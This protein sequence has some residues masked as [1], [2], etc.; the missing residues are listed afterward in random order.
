[1]TGGSRD[2]CIVLCGAAGRADHVHD[3]GLGRVPGEF[4]RCG[5]RGEIQH[6]IGLRENRERVVRECYVERADAGEFTCILAEMGRARP[7]DCTD[8]AR[9]LCRM[10]RPD[11]RLPHAPGCAD[12]DETHPAHVL[13]PA[14]VVLAGTRFGLIAV[15]FVSSTMPRPRS[16][17]SR[18]NRA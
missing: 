15:T 9:A 12:D 13:L 7:F 10:D 8:D 18:W 2:L 6:A 1:M 16:F 3:A 5:R 17:W 14:A 11:Q 4:D